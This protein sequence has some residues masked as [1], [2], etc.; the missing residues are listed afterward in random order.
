MSPVR[1]P[2]C[3]HSNLL[4]PST[5]WLPPVQ[6]QAPPGQQTGKLDPQPA[7]DQVPD[8]KGGSKLY[9][10]AGKLKGRK[11]IITGGDSGIGQSTAVLFAMEGADSLITY[12]PEE[13]KDAEET[14]KMCEKYG[15]KCY[16]IGVDL[17]KKENCQKVI[18]EAM[19]KLGGINILFNNHAYQM[20]IEDIHDLSE[21]QWV[22]TFDTNIHRTPSSLTPCHPRLADSARQPSSTSPN[23]PSPT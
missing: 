20:M 12:L 19:S 1:P 2:Q 3:H 13:G 8:G 7:I 11:A 23:T 6:H 9:Q 4:T 10:A 16:A 14:I 18:D 17:K 5:G 21:E 22:H 15:G